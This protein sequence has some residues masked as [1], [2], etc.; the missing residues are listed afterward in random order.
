MNG[1]VQL[2]EQNILESKFYEAQQLFKSAQR[3]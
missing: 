1:I 3:R 2:A